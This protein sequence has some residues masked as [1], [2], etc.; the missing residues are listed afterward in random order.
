MPTKPIPIPVPPP[1]DSAAIL[2][3][4]LTLEQILK[5][6]RRCA[7]TWFRIER[8]GDGPPRTV[9]GK[10]IL[11]RRDAFIEWLRSR[12][13]RNGVRLSANGRP[14]ILRKQVSPVGRVR[15]VRRARVA[16]K[17]R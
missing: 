14:R 12:E 16:R 15:Y 6:L 5:A 8:T 3:E 4:Y 11:Y 7:R 1:E 13:E 10:T 9:I 17:D 2:A